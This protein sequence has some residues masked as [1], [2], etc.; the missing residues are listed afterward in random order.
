[1]P[2][3]H[4]QHG[5]ALVIAL[6][7][8]ALAATAAAALVGQQNLQIRRAANVF[9]SD[10]AY[11]Y[12]LGAE[13]WAMRVLTEDRQE[14]DFDTLGEDWATVLPP[15]DVP[16]GT[17]S[18]LIVDLQGRFNLN[19]LIRDDKLDGLSLERLQRLLDFAGAPTSVAQS[20]ADWLDSDIEASGAGGAEDDYYLG[21]ERP[22]RTANRAMASASELRLVRGIE[23]EAFEV[24]TRGRLLEEGQRDTPLVIALPERTAINVNTAPAGVL[25]A[26]GLPEAAADQVVADREE[27]PF[28]RVEDFLS[29]PS[30]SD[31][32][33]LREEGQ[34]DDL[35]VVS[36]FFLVYVQVEVA[37]ARVFLYSVLYRD[38]DGMISVV[39]RSQGAL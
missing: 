17:L 3:A 37:R 13:A 26:I 24:L 22:Y 30:V 35:G 20:V 34:T 12:A 8:V 5:V 29:H 38:Q 19:N 4:P 11:L 2:T 33:L 6:L 21:L 23:E 31:V 16:G 36:D 28:E 10:Q 15:L 18:G 1:M 7:I 32:E 14:N 27:E 39:M 25:V 9:Y